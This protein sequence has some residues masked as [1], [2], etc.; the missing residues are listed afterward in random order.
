M[1]KNLQFVL[2][3]MV[4][5]SDLAYNLEDGDIYTLLYL[6][7]AAAITMIIGSVKGSKKYVVLSALTLCALVI[8]QTRDFWMSISWWIYL[9]VVGIALVAYA[10]KR[11]WSRA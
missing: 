8:Y 10:A 2:V 6:G 7:V 5:L 3:A 9:F 1:L 11:E 4:F